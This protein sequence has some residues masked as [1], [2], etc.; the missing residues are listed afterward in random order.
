[1]FNSFKIKSARIFTKKKRDKSTGTVRERQ[2]R[3]PHY[4]FHF[5]QRG[6]H[7]MV[8]R[9]FLQSEKNHVFCFA[10]FFVVS[11]VPRDFLF[12]GIS[13]YHF[14][15]SLPRPGARCRTSRHV[16]LK[17]THAIRARTAP[18]FPVS[19]FQNW[20]G[21]LIILSVGFVI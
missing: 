13:S 10:L 4:S 2:R 21:Q 20:F 9:T 12:R 16:S 11:T 18:S 6:T 3:I 8:S 7:S 19:N 17:S 14:R 15:S 5:P 1:M